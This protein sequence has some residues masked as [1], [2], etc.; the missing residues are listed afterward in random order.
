MSIA[1]EPRREANVAD[2]ETIGYLV[3][4]CSADLL[5]SMNLVFDLGQQFFRRPII[6][7]RRN[8]TL[9]PLDGYRDIGLEYSRTAKR[10]DLAESFCVHRR[11]RGRIERDFDQLALALY[12]AMVKCM[13]QLDRITDGV[14][15]ALEEYFKSIRPP[16]PAFQCNSASYMQLNYYRPKEHRRQILQDAHEDGHYLT[17]TKS[18]KPG[19]E[20]RNGP[21]EFVPANIDEDHILVMPGEI[22]SLLSGGRIDPLIHRVMADRTV[23]ERLSL[24]YFVNPNV[25]TDNTLKPWIPAKQEACGVDILQRAVENPT[26][27]GLPPLPIAAPE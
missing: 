11:Y 1:E 13:Q 21:K 14:T 26:R 19:L 2:L 23:N 3:H 5:N 6:E 16:R 8:A 17:F 15:I 25:G 7:K 4:C 27:F 20:V 9:S 18:T 12:D 22:L 10:P 24:M